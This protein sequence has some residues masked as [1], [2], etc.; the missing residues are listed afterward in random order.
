MVFD[1]TKR[2]ARDKTFDNIKD[3]LHLKIARLDSSRS[4]SPSARIGS[5]EGETMQ[6]HSQ[7]SNLIS[8][9]K[10]TPKDRDKFLNRMMIYEERKQKAIEML[11][12]ARR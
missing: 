9:R 6:R 7:A 1:I 4:L 5:P 12:G 8:P 10:F 2:Q 11:Q 3:V